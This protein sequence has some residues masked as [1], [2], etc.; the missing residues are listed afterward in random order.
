MHCQYGAHCQGAGE[1]LSLGDIGQTD[2]ARAVDYRLKV[3]GTRSQSS[4][5]PRATTAA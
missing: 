2:V 5:Q 4:A 1:L 3:D